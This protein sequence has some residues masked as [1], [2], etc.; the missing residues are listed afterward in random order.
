MLE[1]I[2]E[3]VQMEQYLTKLFYQ[4]NFP[5]INNLYTI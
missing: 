3:L 5:L 4:R 2:L 1:Q